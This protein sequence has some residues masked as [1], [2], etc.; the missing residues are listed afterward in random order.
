VGSTADGRL[1]LSLSLREGAE[2]E[3]SLARTI[4]LTRRNQLKKAC[5][6]IPSARQVLALARTAQE[7][8]GMLLVAILANRSAGSLV[9]L[10]ACGVAGLLF[11]AILHPPTVSSVQLSGTPSSLSQGRCTPRVRFDV[12]ARPRQVVVRLPPLRQLADLRL[13]IIL[14]E[15]VEPLPR[16]AMIAIFVA[17]SLTAG[18]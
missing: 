18:S 7:R 5:Q 11:R 16:R 3:S 13:D 14:G 6:S 12:E 17:S 15:V 1:R 2:I 4:R 9:I 10:L 8:V